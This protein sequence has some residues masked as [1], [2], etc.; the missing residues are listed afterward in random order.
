MSSSLNRVFGYGCAAL[1]AAFF[2]TKAIFIKLAFQEQVDASLMLAYRMLFATPVFVA[3]GIWAYAQ[4]RAKGLPPPDRKSVA[5]AIL[6]GFLGY[7]VASA[8]DFAGLQ[9]ISASLER[10]VLFTYPLF[11]MF[12]GAALYRQPMTVFGVA[13]AAVTYIGLAIVFTADLPHGG[14]DTAIG[15]FLVLGAAISFAWHQILAKRCLAPLGI[16]LFTSIALSA[17]GV[18][19]VMHHII[20]GSGSFAA[21]PRFLWLSFGCA[22]VATVLPTF[23]VNAGLVHVSPQAVSM[24]ATV[25]PIVTIGLAIEILG[26]PFTVT[27]AI[28]SALVLAGVGLFTWGDSRAKPS[29]DVPLSSEPVPTAERASQP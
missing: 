17:A 26:E 25:S 29:R 28:G 3:I 20:F 10:L 18:F 6:T 9:Y 1:G 5:W 21:S 24:I 11:V 27:D 22:M 16:A 13:A 4:R 12:L 2:S 14:R 7:Y 19:C 15:T 8:F 23:L